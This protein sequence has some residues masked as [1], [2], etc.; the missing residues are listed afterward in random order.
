MKKIL[1]IAL[2]LVLAWS[3]VGCGGSKSGNSAGKTETV[4]VVGEWGTADE[5]MKWMEDNVPGVDTEA[6]K[7]YLITFKDDGT[8]IYDYGDADIEP[9]GGTYTISGNKIT[10]VGTGAGVFTVDGNKIVHSDGVANYVR[11]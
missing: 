8:Y 10:M 5:L 3:I 2:C 4:S 7:N 11:K 6:M 1:A 9:E